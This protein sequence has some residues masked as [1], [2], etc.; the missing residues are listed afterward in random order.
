MEFNFTEPRVNFIAFNYN[1][2]YR[3]EDKSDSI[4][5]VTLNQEVIIMIVVIL[6]F[7]FNLMSLFSVEIFH[8]VRVI[9]LSI[10]DYSY[11]IVIVWIKKKIL[12]FRKKKL[13]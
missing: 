1:L 2:F 13:N 8:I 11:I 3:I 12:Q 7:Y 4:F 5:L 10:I 9:Y 6:Y